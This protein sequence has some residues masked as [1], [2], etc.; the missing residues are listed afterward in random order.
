MRKITKQA[1]QAFLNGES[2]NSGNTKVITAANTTK[3][4]LHDTC[5]ARIDSH[6]MA[7]NPQGYCTKTTKERLNALPRVSLV[8]RNFT[9]YLNGASIPLNCTAWTYV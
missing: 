8:Q 9:W 7:I 2:F 3:L 1:I 6:G 4:L 5:I